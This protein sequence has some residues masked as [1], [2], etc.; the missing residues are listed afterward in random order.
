MTDNDAWDASI[1]K[2]V[3]K[4]IVVDLHNKNADLNRTEQ[5]TLILKSKLKDNFLGRHI[6]DQEAFSNCPCFKDG[7][8]AKRNSQTIRNNRFWLSK[9]SD[10]EQNQSQQLK[11]SKSKKSSSKIPYELRD[12][13]NK[14][15]YWGDDN[16][17]F[18]TSLG[19]HHDEQSD[20]N[21]N[22][23]D[24]AP[25]DEELDKNYESLNIGYSHGGHSNSNHNDFYS[26]SLDHK[27]IKTSSSSNKVNDDTV[28]LCSNNPRDTTFNY[29]VKVGINI[30]PLDAVFQE[31]AKFISS[32][33]CVEEI[34]QENIFD[35]GDKIDNMQREDLV[36][37]EE[38]LI[39]LE[40]KNE[41]KIYTVL[42]KLVFLNIN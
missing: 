21:F 12:F 30:F 26:S 35:V 28:I 41:Q 4:Q 10:I 1:G 33:C 13:N 32:G 14:G 24:D 42:G 9:D 8:I 31:Y 40:L 11:T 34:R 25:A 15:S 6:R 39:F 16:A 36:E 17:D 23:G 5:L 37:T 7:S 22:N 18:E 20:Q 2:Q 27:H 29:G 19:Q 38:D 3:E